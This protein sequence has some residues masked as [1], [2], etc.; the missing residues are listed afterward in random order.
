MPISAALFYAA[1]EGKV[2][3]LRFKIPFETQDVLQTVN[4]SKY[5]SK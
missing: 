4:G 1:L 3:I 5:F 2:G